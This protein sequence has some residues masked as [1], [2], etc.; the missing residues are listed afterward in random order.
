MK[1][2]ELESRIKRIEQR[3]GIPK[4]NKPLLNV[5][6]NN[7]AYEI[8]P[9]PNNMARVIAHIHNNE[10]LQAIK[11]FRECFSCGLLEAKTFVELMIGLKHYR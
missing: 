7:E 6:E 11:Q 8:G 5:V 4:E 9:T 10:P 2:D 3:L 1:I